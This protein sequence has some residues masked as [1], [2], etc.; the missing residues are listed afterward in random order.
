MSV[1]KK[2]LEEMDERQN[3]V[4]RADGSKYPM[5]KIDVCVAKAIVRKNMRDYWIPVHDMLPEHA[6][7]PSELHEKRFL[8]TTPSGEEKVVRRLRCAHGV[9]I[10][11]D[12]YDSVKVIAW[13]YIVPYNPERSDNHDGE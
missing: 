2:I 1:Q 12:G 3:M 7:D 13:R 9:Y 5:G 10:W 6:Y 4:E 11:F 8:I